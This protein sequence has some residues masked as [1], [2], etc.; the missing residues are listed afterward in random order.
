VE[1]LHNILKSEVCKGREKGINSQLNKWDDT[2]EDERLG[3]DR[4][5][6]EWDLWD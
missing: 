5:V 6:V 1:V 2:R 3:G 4:V